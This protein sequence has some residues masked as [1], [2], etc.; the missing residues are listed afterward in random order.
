MADTPPRR[1][2]HFDNV[3]AIVD[4][5]TQLHSAGY[6]S[7]GQWSLGQVCG[8]LAILMECSLDGFP[9]KMPL[10]YRLLGRV[11]KK[12]LLRRGMPTGITFPAAAVRTLKPPEVSDEEGLARLRQA[13]DRLQ[14]ESPREPS[15]VLGPM[16]AEAWRAFHC[17]HAE[18]HLS[19]LDPE[20]S[21][22]KEPGDGHD[23]DASA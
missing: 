2:L 13:V 10:R 1:R 22:D 19:F 20:V 5:A 23:D 18:L 4:E 9:F 16:T 8:H 11:I 21:R 12:R 17:R 7:L 3:A 15:P 6:R 14:N